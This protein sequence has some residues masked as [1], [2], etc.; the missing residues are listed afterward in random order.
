MLI[1][2][3]SLTDIFNGWN[4]PYPFILYTIYNLSEG[5]IT[6]ESKNYFLDFQN[7]LIKINLK[8]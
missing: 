7:L 2:E 1:I 8:N 3:N 6:R 4:A 5:T